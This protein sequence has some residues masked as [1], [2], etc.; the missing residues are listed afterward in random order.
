MAAS[1]SSSCA[2]NL[3]RTREIVDAGRRL[4]SLCRAA[5]ALFVVNDR[6]D[7]A[8]ACAADGVHVGQDD[9]GVE[10]ARRVLGAERL[11][12]L[13]THSRD[14]LEAAGGSGADYASVGPVWET[15]TKE[16]PARGRPR[17]RPFRGRTRR[18]SVLRDRGDR[19]LER[20]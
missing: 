3:G 7:L 6:P 12:G 16:G 5:G 8:V 14:Q 2:T 1:T 19:R 4:A 11:I 17:A 9:A 20:R 18:A 10:E 13:S 15:P